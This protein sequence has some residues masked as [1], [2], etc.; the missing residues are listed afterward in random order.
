MRVFKWATQ[1]SGKRRAKERLNSQAEVRLVH[2]PQARLRR[3]SRND[4]GLCA[5]SITAPVNPLLRHETKLGKEVS[6]SVLC[7]QRGAMAWR[8]RTNL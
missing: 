5:L 6:V 1:D 3:D 4:P 8:D 2:V 7:V